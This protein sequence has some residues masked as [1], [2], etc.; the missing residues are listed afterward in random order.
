MEGEREWENAPCALANRQAG[1][2]MVTHQRVACSWNT[3]P[4]MA[5]S[6]QLPEDRASSPPS[7][8]IETAFTL[9]S[10]C[11]YRG[12]LQFEV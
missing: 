8:N 7:P 12:K 4:D 6:S 5:G 9:S 3:R 2:L 10:L 1:Q 11:F